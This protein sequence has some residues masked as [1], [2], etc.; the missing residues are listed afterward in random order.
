MGNR[1]LGVRVSWQSAIGRPQAFD[2]EPRV[3]CIQKSSRTREQ[4]PNW[5]AHR[6]HSLVGHLY[7]HF[8]VNESP[9]L[10]QA[11]GLFGRVVVIR[12]VVLACTFGVYVYKYKD[13]SSLF[14]FSW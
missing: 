8:L 3:R 7:T 6:R 2:L 1:Q 13:K 4:S 10:L 5:A 11:T 9:R 12:N 14:V